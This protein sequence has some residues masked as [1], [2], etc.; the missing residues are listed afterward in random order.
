MMPIALACKSK[1]LS[2]TLRRLAGISGFTSSYSKHGVPWRREL[3]L[4]KKAMTHCDTDVVRIILLL[5]AYDANRTR[6]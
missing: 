3:A 6:V 4:V 2:E 1:S 5:G